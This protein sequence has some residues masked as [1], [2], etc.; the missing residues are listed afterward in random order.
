MQHKA[1]IAANPVTAGLAK[2]T[3]EYPLCFTF[4]ANRKGAGLKPSTSR[5]TALRL[6]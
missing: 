6:D 4:L 1:Y 5:R 2:T 3:G